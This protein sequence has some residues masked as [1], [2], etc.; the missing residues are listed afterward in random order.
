MTRASLQ[1]RQ[2]VT[3]EQLDSLFAKLSQLGRL[4]QYDGSSGDANISVT[5]MA[6]TVVTASYVAHARFENGEA[7]IALRLVEDE[8]WRITFFNVSSPLFLK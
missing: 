2:S 5:A 3:D 6:G 7:Q 4:Q 8:G 1:L